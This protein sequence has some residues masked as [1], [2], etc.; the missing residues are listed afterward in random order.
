MYMYL[1]YKY[2]PWDDLLFDDVTV[3]T[4]ESLNIHHV[5]WHIQSLSRFLTIPTLSHILHLLAL[6][7]N[8][9]SVSSCLSHSFIGHFMPKHQLWL[10][11]IM[12]AGGKNCK[13]M[14]GSLKL[15]LLKFLMELIKDCCLCG[16]KCVCVN[17]TL[18]KIG[19]IHSWEGKLDAFNF[20][21]EFFFCVRQH[22][23]ISVWKR[24]L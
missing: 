13:E 11:P 2:C 10:W 23:K 15:E 6:V 19:S 22:L 8:K 1:Q 17:R 5:S 9:S 12:A 21:G 4:L 7:S 18:L 24:N 3:D 14:G 20:W 16:L